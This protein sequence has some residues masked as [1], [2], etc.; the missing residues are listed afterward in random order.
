M[1]SMFASFKKMK[2]AVTMVF[3]TNF[4]VALVFPSILIYKPL[5]GAYFC[6]RP[7]SEVNL[8]IAWMGVANLGPFF[9]CFAIGTY[10]ARSHKKPEHSKCSVSASVFSSLIM[11]FCVGVIYIATFND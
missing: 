7:T 8:Q 3:L 9:I 1:T 11:I 6:I 4:L 5:P 2:L 10:F